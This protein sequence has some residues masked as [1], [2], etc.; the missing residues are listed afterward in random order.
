MQAEVVIPIP[1]PT[2]TTGRRG[3]SNAEAVDEA[4]DVDVVD[5]VDDDD[6]EDED[7][8]SGEDKGAAGQ[9]PKSESRSR[10]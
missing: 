4:M 2:L 10:L 8:D 7:E 3:N 1:P 6:D 5:L 9:P